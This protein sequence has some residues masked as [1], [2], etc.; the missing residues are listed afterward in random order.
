M[1]SRP[2]ELSLLF[3]DAR[4]HYAW[5]AEPVDDALLRRIYDL[6]K[7]APTGGNAQPLRVVYVRAAEAKER[8]RPALDPMNVDKTMSAPVTAILA[9]DERFYD[10]IPELLPARPQLR[11]RFVQMPDEIR[12]RMNL[13]NANM[14]AGY[15][16]LAARALGLDVGPMG[17]FDPQKVDEAFLGG[18]SWRA[19]LLV[20]LGHG[21]PT[22]LFPRNPR[23]SFDDAG[24]IL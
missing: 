24:R 7:M 2:E 3:S 12:N 9:A 11:E 22:K 19:F 13:Q 20:N 5:L 15:F 16:V 10:K 8:L 18:T 23:L 1:N 21:D 17:G 6:T 4:T 14:Q